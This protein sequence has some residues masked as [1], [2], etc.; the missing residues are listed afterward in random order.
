MTR[1][2]EDMKVV[3]VFRDSK[4]VEYA[5]LLNGQIVRVLPKK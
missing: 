3:K 5:K 4:G 2:L 1:V